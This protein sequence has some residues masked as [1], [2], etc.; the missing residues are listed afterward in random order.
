MI[1]YTG[2]RYELEVSPAPNGHF[3]I[4][5]TPRYPSW[6]HKSPKHLCRVLATQTSEVE[7]TYF[8]VDQVLEVLTEYH[9]KTKLTGEKLKNCLLKMHD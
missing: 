8:D 2:E 5:R 4:T 7:L 9:C 6:A 1:I 3:Y